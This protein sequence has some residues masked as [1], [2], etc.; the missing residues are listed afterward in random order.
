MS[1]LP[2][3]S[4]YASSPPTAGGSAY[5]PLGAL[6]S[7]AESGDVI[8]VHVPTLEA[9]DLAEVRLATSRAPGTAAMDRRARHRLWACLAIVAFLFGPVVGSG[10]RPDLTLAGVLLGFVAGV[11]VIQGSVRKEA[12]EIAEATYWFDRSGVRWQTPSMEGRT[13]WAELWMV[14]GHRCLV[15]VKGTSFTHAIPKRLARPDLVARIC[16]LATPAGATLDPQPLGSTTF[17]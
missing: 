12:E 8:T 7:T 1:F 2:P 13:S 15:L 11:L 16:D 10:N 4:P 5:D 9:K 3:P 6:G 14:E 17:A